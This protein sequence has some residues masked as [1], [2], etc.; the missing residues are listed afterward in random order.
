MAKVKCTKC[1]GECCTCWG[2][3]PKK[4]KDGLCPNCQELVKQ[5]T[6]AESKPK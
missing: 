4:Y 5:Q 2:C 6:N 1:G 3:D